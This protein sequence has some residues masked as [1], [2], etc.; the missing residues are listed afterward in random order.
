[1]AATGRYIIKSFIFATKDYYTTSKTSAFVKTSRPLNLRKLH[2]QKGIYS[3]LWLPGT[4]TLALQP[5]KPL[6]AH[7]LK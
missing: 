6:G 7:Q 2:Y 1:M 4:M 5:K 3:E